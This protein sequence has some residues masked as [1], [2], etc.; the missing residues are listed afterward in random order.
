VKAVGAGGVALGV[1]LLVAAPAGAAPPTATPP[2]P[3]SLEGGAFGTYL[4]AFNL[5]SP[6]G[7]F[8]FGPKPQV[9]TPPS[10][11]GNTLQAQLGPQSFGGMPPL[12]P[13]PIAVGSSEAQTEGEVAGPQV[14]S[15]AQLQ[16][17]T[18]QVGSGAGALNIQLGDNSSVSG[19]DAQCQSQQGQQGNQVTAKTTFTSGTING[20]PVP[21]NPPPDTTYVVSYPTASP[22]P[23]GTLTVVLNEQVKG[24]S[25]D[26]HPGILVNAVHVYVGSPG[27]TYSNQD[28]AI[29]GEA[30]CE[31]AIIPI[32]PGI[33]PEAPF[34]ALL[35]LSAL[36]VAGTATIVVRSRRRRRSA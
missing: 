3:P 23:F 2:A 12:S 32:P 36:A 13:P 33:I 25:S 4:N 9:V 21:S 11:G 28:S 5:G 27:T 30:R 8:N 22:K 29:F 19:V 26:H 31:V 1:A 15:E 6:Y 34:A 24:Q 20:Q 10:G 18:I 7:T 17:V 14:Q 16:D 35:P